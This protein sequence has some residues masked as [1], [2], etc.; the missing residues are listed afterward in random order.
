MACT[1]CPST[2]K[3]NIAEIEVVHRYSKKLES[4]TFNKLK[5]KENGGR[6]N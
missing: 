6:S 1:T 2:F 3:E 4:N 5:F